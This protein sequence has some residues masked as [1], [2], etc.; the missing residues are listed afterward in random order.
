ML[1]NSFSWLPVNAGTDAEPV[2]RLVSDNAVAQYLRLRS[3]GV[4]LKDLL[5][6]S[7]EK[8]MKEDVIKLK[9]IP[10]RT[11][12]ATNAVKTVL[13]NWDGQPVLVTGPETEELLGILTPHDLL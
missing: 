9:L 4:P 5:V 10:A 2:W 1:V 12:R 8:A 11:C 3:N 13:V 7:L 6:Q